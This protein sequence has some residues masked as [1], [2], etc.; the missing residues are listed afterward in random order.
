M[1][2][3]PASR[4]TSF[5]H[6]FDIVDDLGDELEYSSEELDRFFH[7]VATFD[8]VDDEDDENE[9]EGE[10]D[11]DDEQVLSQKL[12][13]LS[14]H[15]MTEY[16]S[17]T[18]GGKRRLTTTADSLIMSK[19]SK[20]L[21]RLERDP[22]PAYLS[23]DN[24]SFRR[25]MKTTIG[26]DQLRQVAICIHHIGALQIQKQ[27]SLA[28]LQSGTGEWSEHELD[29][30]PIDR[31]VW[32]SQV[33][34][35]LS[36]ACSSDERQLACEQLVQQRLRDMNENILHYQRHRDET[37]DEYP[38]VFTPAVRQSIDGFV[39]QYGMAPLRMKRD[40]KIAL[41]KYAYQAEIIDRHYRQ[42]DP[43]AY[44]VDRTV[45]DLLLIFFLDGRGQTTLR[46]QARTGNGMR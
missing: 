1:T 40:L 39:E 7:G 16:E 10:D 26:I 36:V 22:A 19:K 9:D 14:T 21:E 4:S 29:L 41:L 5:P 3:T 28:Y 8:D 2:N 32:P 42:A 45:T 44:Q 33:T 30:L 35:A 23:T 34:S 11:D 37:I 13:Q 15:D 17:S 31:R 27:V 12:S 43:N 24:D 38:N 25:A 6:I 46:R 18:A 20:R